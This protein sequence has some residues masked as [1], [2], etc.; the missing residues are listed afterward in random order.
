MSNVLNLNKY[1]KQKRKDLERSNICNDIADNFYLLS[2]VDIDYNEVFQSLYDSMIPTYFL[3]DF[4]KKVISQ[5]NE[6]EEKRRMLCTDLYNQYID[7]KVYF[8]KKT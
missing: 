8:K 6:Y 1:K 7:L 5:V 4:S 2:E 3:R